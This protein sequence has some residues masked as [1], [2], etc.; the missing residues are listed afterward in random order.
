MPHTR[1]FLQK[2]SSGHARAVRINGA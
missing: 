2:Q 1:I